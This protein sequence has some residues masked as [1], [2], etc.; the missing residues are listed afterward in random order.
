MTLYEFNSLSEHDKFDIVFTK[1]KFI[2][3][4]LKWKSALPF[5]Q[6]IC[7]LWKLNMTE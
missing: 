7:S 6:L 4:G 1:G 5:M 2:I 3:T